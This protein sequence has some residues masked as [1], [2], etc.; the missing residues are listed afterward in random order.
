MGSWHTVDDAVAYGRGILSGEKVRLRETRE[1][2]YAQ[3]ADWWL[4][5]GVSV[6][7]TFWVRPTPPES[8]VEMMHGWS[9]NSGTG[10][11]FAVETLDGATLIGHATLFG[12]DKNRC[13]TLAIV[14]GPPHWGSGYGTDTVRT[15]VRYGFA[16][17]GLHRIQLETFSYNARAIAAYAKV[18][19]V[20]EGRRRETRLHDGVWYDDVVMGLLE[21]EWRAQAPRH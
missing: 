2:D 7:Q 6:L 5:P 3:L 14:L 9:A 20:E 4:D 17:M 10:A 13:A 18:G 19:F 16:E 1:T 15:L 8:V 12:V 11:G 21:N